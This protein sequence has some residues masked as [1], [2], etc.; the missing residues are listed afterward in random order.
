M[1]NTPYLTAT[2]NCLGL[3]FGN[4]TVFIAY[5]GMTERILQFITETVGSSLY[6]KALRCIK[7]LRAAAVKSNDQVHVTGTC[8]NIS[9]ATSMSSFVA[10]LTDYWHILGAP[11]DCQLLFLINEVTVVK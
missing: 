8:D 5:T 7:K 10:E 4:V 9:S 6:E 2:N 11:G 1:C 3:V